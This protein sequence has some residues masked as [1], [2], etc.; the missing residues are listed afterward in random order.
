[1]NNVMT[2]FWRFL[3]EHSVEIPIIQRDYAQGRL[4]KE[5]L[6][7][8]FLK[9]LKQALDSCVP[10]KLDF[11]YGSMERGILNP[12]DGQQRLTTLWLLH[13]YLAYMAGAMDKEVKRVLAKFTYETRISSREFCG[14]LTAFDSLPP[15][16]SE[17][18]TVL[19][20]RTV[21]GKGVPF[22]ENQPKWHA[23][24]ITPAQ[25]KECEDLLL[26]DWRQP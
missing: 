18:P 4:G 3:N 15:P 11:V 19:I 25:F 8:T 21:K 2:T 7:K 20:C 24:K 14:F 12:L 16:R 9:D 5:E 10:L 26:R 13:W 23:G 22:M 6:R 1:M 17:K